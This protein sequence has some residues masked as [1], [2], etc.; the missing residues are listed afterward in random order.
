MGHL[1]K[2]TAFLLQES[3]EELKKITW[4]KGE[5]NIDLDFSKLAAQKCQEAFK[6]IHNDNEFPFL[7]LS[8]NTPDIKL[9]FSTK[10]NNE[11]MVYERKIELK[12]GESNIIPG[13]T[14]KNLDFNIW[15]IF[16][17]RQ[18]KNTNFSFRYGRYYKGVD[19]ENT[20]LFQ[21]RTP[22]PRLK[23]DKYQSIKEEPDIM[24]VEQNIY[25]IENYAKAALNRL[26]ANYQDKIKYS[27]QDDL[28]KLIIKNLINN[29][30]EILLKILDEMNISLED[31]LA[32]LN[33]NKK[34]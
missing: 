5:A 31:F 7:Q 23:W 2:E 30:Q 15:V 13:S 4:S 3:Q 16:V 25:W 29:H 28:I 10:I 1:V 11:N 8:T 34:L 24:L 12:S 32:E 22:R 26:S 14:I 27:W 6:S 21:D 17:L 20:A 9:S 19:I 18:N 33:K